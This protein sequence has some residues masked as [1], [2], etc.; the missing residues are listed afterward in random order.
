MTIFSEIYRF[1][2]GY[3]SSGPSV[4]KGGGVGYEELR[5]VEYL[6]IMPSKGAEPSDSALQF[7]VNILP[8]FLY[9]LVG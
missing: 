9:R 6:R 8:L 7:W 1:Y 3:R 4:Y 2:F 5:S